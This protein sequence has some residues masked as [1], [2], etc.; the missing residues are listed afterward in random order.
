MQPP[1]PARTEVVDFLDRVLPDGAS[2]TLVAADRDGVVLCQGFGMADREAR[3]P[4][5]CDTV[6]DIGSVTKQFTAAAVLKL[7]M[8][9][10]LRVD[11]PIGRFLGPV[12][13]DKAGITVEHLL[14]HTSGLAPSLGDDYERLTRAGLV[15]QAMAAPLRSTPGSTYRYSNL[16]Y[17]LL[18]AI[19]QKA[20]GM[21]YERFLADHLWQ[22]AGMTSTGY[23]LPPWRLADV[24]VEYDA[25][26]RSHGRP[27]DHP[28]AASGP[29]WNLRGNGGLLSTANDMWR[30]HRALRRATVL[31]RRSISALFRPRVLEEP[32]GE[33]SYGYGWVLQDTPLG[34]VA[35]HN[36]GNGLSYAELARVLGTGVMVFWVSNRVRDRDRGWDLQRL[37]SRITG[38]TLLRLRQT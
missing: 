1:D 18:A 30:W 33:T 2:G 21:A 7:Q 27:F 26:G 32:G 22:P 38:G 28:W 12:P 9:G 20:S 16:G 25:R 23:V 31:D 17:S 5:T 6:Y 15:T 8:Q 37:G 35:W 24:A 34:P 4:A 19:V 11:D 10:R 36:G 14:T 3:T 13:P 29:W